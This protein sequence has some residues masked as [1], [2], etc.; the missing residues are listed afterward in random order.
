MSS[1]EFAELLVSH[2]SVVHVPS[3][4]GGAG[5]VI[6]CMHGGLLPVC[7]HE[8]SIDLVEFGVLVEQASVEAVQQACRTVA[9]M[10]NEEIGHRARAAYDHVRQVHTRDE[11]RKNYAAFAA[12]V[13]ARFE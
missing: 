4:E 2:G 13:A 3:S 10:S 12:S 11:F 6:H 1:A 9:K 7:N 5:N 8:S